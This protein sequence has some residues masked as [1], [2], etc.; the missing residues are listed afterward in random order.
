MSN[1]TRNDILRITE[2]VSKKAAADKTPTVD[3]FVKYA[4]DNNLPPAVLKDVLDTY[5]TARQLDSFH[6]KANRA[7]TPEPHNSAEIVRDY[8][9]GMVPAVKEASVPRSAYG[10]PEIPV[11]K[12]ASVRSLFPTREGFDGTVKSATPATTF[13]GEVGR[14]TMIRGTPDEQMHLHVKAAADLAYET[15]T[16]AVDEAAKKAAR[17]ARDNPTAFHRLHQAILSEDS[18]KWADVMDAVDYQAKKMGATL[19][20][21]STP[22]RRIMDAP[23]GLYGLFVKVAEALEKEQEFLQAYWDNQETMKAAETYQMRDDTTGEVI[24]IEEMDLTSLGPLADIVDGKP[25]FKPDKN[26]LPQRPAKSLASDPVQ[27]IKADSV[28]LVPGLP[29]PGL[30]GTGMLKD[31]AI[32]AIGDPGARRKADIE[33]YVAQDY[34][35]EL[36]TNVLRL[37]HTDPALESMNPTDR[38]EI[39]KTLL[40]YNPS[41]GND[42]QAM[43]ALMR[44]AAQYGGSLPTTVLKEI[45]S[46]RKTELE[47]AKLKRDLA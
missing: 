27:K 37:I 8:V 6:K 25:V 18:A 5:N 1:Y 44:E 10:R 7:D 45:S 31:L 35:N 12:S 40:K 39:A 3:A 46:L 41:L 43:R 15:V 47:N 2:T 24:T 34:A 19:K 22:V 30:S 23:D 20:K 32:R 9:A 38:A 36:E 13:F 28:K 4:R 21:A 33:A 17:A 29:M 16:K 14:P 42:M 11:A 26:G